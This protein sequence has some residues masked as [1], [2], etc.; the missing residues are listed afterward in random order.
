MQKGVGGGNF[1]ILAR[2]RRRGARGGGSGGRRHG[3]AAGRDPAVPRRRGAERE[4]GRL[5]PIKSMIASTNDAF[6]PTLRAVT[7]SE[8]PEGVNCVL[9]IVIN[10]LDAPSI[11]AAMR[12]GI[13][14]ACRAGVV[15][16]TAGNYGGKLGPHH[17]HLRQIMAEGPGERRGRRHAAGAARRRADWAS[18]WARVRGSASGGPGPSRCVS[19]VARP[20]WVIS[21][22]SAASARR[23]SG[24][25][26]DLEQ[27]GSGRGTGGGSGDRKAMSD[28]DVGLAMS[29]GSVEVRGDAGVNA[30]GA[31]PGA[32]AGDHGGEIVVRGSV[33]GD[34]GAG[35]GE[36]WSCDG[37]R[38]GGTR[39]KE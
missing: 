20:C 29:G 3:P 35:C 15:C 28:E 33:A 34:A 17:F 5:A 39:G 25:T 26:G 24:S 6:C 10:G 23:A 21:S 18:C 32:A 22:R 36:G 16:I 27:R 7:K 31:P 37:G 8:L 9:E 2:S 30:G 12:V 38:G 13:D 19:R 1:L 4:Q 11:E 14:A